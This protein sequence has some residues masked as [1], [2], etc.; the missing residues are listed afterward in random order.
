M[1]VKYFKNGNE[2]FQCVGTDG[3]FFW[4]EIDGLS[5]KFEQQDCD[6]VVTKSE[7]TASD[8]KHGQQILVNKELC[9]V[10]HIK[11]FDFSVTVKDGFIICFDSE[12][13]IF[14]TDDR[15]VVELLVLS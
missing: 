6:I 2:I 13:R 9:R 7:Y 8:F 14:E 3:G 15:D 10:D 11:P 1:N 4:A 5:Q 12:N